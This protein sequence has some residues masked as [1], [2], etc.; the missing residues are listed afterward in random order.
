MSYAAKELKMMFSRDQIV[1][2]EITSVDTEKKTCTALPVSSTGGAEIT[3]ISLC[4]SQGGQTLVIYPKVNTL[5]AL[6]MV[7][8][9]QA[10]LLNAVDAE[11]IE[12]EAEQIHLGLDGQPAVRGED[13]NKNLEDLFKNIQDLCQALTEFSAA[14]GAVSGSGSL[15][16]L[17]AGYSSLASSI[18][19][20]QASLP[21]LNTAL[22]NHLSRKVTIS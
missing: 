15:A 13:L 1:I 9:Q 4:V 14:Q 18:S 21:S 20:V 10:V 6:G 8:E 17:A 16:P 5:A 7:T 12:L 3:G 11:T 19:A 22:G 2:A